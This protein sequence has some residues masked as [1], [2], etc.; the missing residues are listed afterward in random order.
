[1]NLAIV[2]EPKR[3]LAHDGLGIRS[4]AD[5][6]IIALDRADEGFGHSVALRAFKGRRSRLEPDVMSEA[7]CI[8]GDVAASIVG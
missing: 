3:Q 4:R 6:D 2:G 7:S 1:V 5:A 8:A